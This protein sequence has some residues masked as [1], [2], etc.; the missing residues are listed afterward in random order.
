MIFMRRTSLHSMRRSGGV[1]CQ[2][3]LSGVMAIPHGLETDSNQV[4]R[5]QEL[6]LNRFVLSSENMLTSEWI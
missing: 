5:K 6:C 2:V 3:Y 4:V 1:A